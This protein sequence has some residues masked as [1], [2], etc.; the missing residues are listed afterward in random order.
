MGDVPIFPKVSDDFFLF[1]IEDPDAVADWV[2]DIVQHRMPSRFGLHPLEAQV[3]APM[4]RGDAGVT[5]LNQRLQ[6][7]LNPP[8]MGKTEHRISGRLFRVGD[9]VMQTRNNYEKDVFNGDV[10]R[11]TE[12]NLE[13]ATFSASFDNSGDRRITYDWVEVDDLVHAFAISVHKSQG[14]EYAAV[15]MPVL[16][17]HY[18]MLQRNLL[19]TAVT[20]AKRLCVLV[21]TKKAIQIAVRNDKVAKR[22]S[23]LGVRL[24][25]NR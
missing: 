25:R 24:L 7:A 11:L 19:Y 20:R 12:I 5:N 18:M 15:V 3:L 14:S 8:D 17:Q 13:N 16:T 10:G 4:Y 21:G 1:Q 2:V 9:K 6:A 22:Y 23:G